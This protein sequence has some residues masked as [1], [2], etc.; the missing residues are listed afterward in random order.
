[1]SRHLQK[2]TC[3]NGTGHPVCFERV[4]DS[5]RI[6]QY[7]SFRHRADIG[8]FPPTLLRGEMSDQRRREE[9]V[10]RGLVH[11][12]ANLVAPEERPYLSTARTKVIS[13]AKDGVRTLRRF[14][15]L[16]RTYQQV[17]YCCYHDCRGLRPIRG[18]PFVGRLS[19]NA[20]VVGRIGIEFQR[21]PQLSYLLDDRVEDVL[22]PCA[23][24]HLSVDKGLEL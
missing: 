10:R 2:A 21:G 9:R 8:A 20:M 16:G 23:V 24:D 22:L 11:D 15:I 18:R 1:M 3:R 7:R 19:S 12:R 14:R 6:A 5:E 17:R 13:L 4:P